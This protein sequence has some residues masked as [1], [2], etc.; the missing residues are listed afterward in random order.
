MKI[1]DRVEVLGVYCWFKRNER[2]LSKISYRYAKKADKY[3]KV[4]DYRKA[5]ECLKTAMTYE[6]LSLNETKALNSYLKQKDL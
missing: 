3:D 4:G 6:L 5:A 1:K 2:C